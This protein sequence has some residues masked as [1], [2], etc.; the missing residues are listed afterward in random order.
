MAMALPEGSDPVLSAID[1]RGIATVTLNRPQRGNAYDE[2][3]L[4]AL[5]EGLESL[6]ARPDL[7]AV[8]IRGAGKH[9]QAGADIDWL[10][11][12][13]AYPPE[14][15]FAASM[16]TTRAM[17]LLNEFPHPTLAVVHGACFGGGCGLVCC[18]DVALA[19][20]AAVFGLTEVR[21]GVAPSPIS[22]HMVQAMGLRHTRRYALTGERF[23]AEEAL[24]IGLIHEIIDEAALEARI[25][26]ILDA[27]LL[28]APGA[29]TATKRSFLGANG[30]TLDARAMALLAHESW[31][32]R[33]SAEGREGTA[34]HRAR[35][36]PAW[37]P[38]A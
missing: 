26:A 24:R 30:L 13:S 10:A 2:D 31:M 5:I 35:R 9:F 7:R 17:Q 12:A 28:G 3:L 25:E 36:K 4:A 14:Q 38:S 18:A 37:Y 15:A 29:I 19:T 32:Q 34:A 11:R 16:A 22:T 20:P 27:I 33:N 6:A 8:V 23:D 1:R 21:V